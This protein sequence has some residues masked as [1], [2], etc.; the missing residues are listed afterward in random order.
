MTD[1]DTLRQSLE[2]QSPRTILKEAFRRYD[3]IALSFSGAEDVALIEMAHK[4]TDKT[5]S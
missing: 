2:D 3:N 4:L 1:I 5:R